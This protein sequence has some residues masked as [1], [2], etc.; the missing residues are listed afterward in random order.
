MI[1]LFFFTES[2]IGYTSNF[3]FS[4]DIFLLCILHTPYGVDSIFLPPCHRRS[5]NLSAPPFIDLISFLI[6]IYSYF[7]PMW[8]TN[9]FHFIVFLF[10][11][12]ILLND[13]FS[14]HLLL[15]SIGCSI[16]E[17]EIVTCRFS[18]I[19]PFSFRIY[20]CGRNLYFIYFHLLF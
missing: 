15:Q 1:V 3:W 4:F 18:F 14:V 6:L 11:L 9:F 7:L 5:K 10:I 20:N 2:E 13:I 19:A 17:F 16:S 8:S 12:S